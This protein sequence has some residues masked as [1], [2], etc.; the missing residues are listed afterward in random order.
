[1]LLKKCP[2][3]DSM[4]VKKVTK[5]VERMIRG[6]LLRIPSVTYWACPNCDEKIFPPQATEKMRDYIDK[7]LKQ[8]TT[9]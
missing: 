2:L 5:T 6:E 7:K 1:M 3:C 8:T 9:V 4:N